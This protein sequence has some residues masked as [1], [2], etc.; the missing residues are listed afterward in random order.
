MTK[1]NRLYAKFLEET[2]KDTDREVIQK[3]FK[4]IFKN[5]KLTHQ[6]DKFNQELIELLFKRKKI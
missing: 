1:I 5:I 3:K 4:K 6:E 2:D